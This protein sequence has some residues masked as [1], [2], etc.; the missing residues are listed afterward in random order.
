[1]IT[2]NVGSTFKFGRVRLLTPH[3]LLVEK[4]PAGTK[5]SKQCDIDK[6]K[7]NEEERLKS[8]ML[9]WAK[10]VAAAVFQLGTRDVL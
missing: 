5:G 2:R 9:E 10:A 3:T 4:I 7:T 8:K 1:M 6:L